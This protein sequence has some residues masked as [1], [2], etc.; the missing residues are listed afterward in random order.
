[1]NCREQILASVQAI[2]QQ[3]GK[4]TFFISDLIDHMRAKGSACN[5]G[6][7]RNQ[8]N[9][10]MGKHSQVNKSTASGLFEHVGHGQYRYTGAT[11]AMAN[12]HLETKTKKA[13]SPI[14]PQPKEITLIQGPETKHGREFLINFGF[15]LAGHWYLDEGKINADLSNLP[16]SDHGLYAFVLGDQVLYIGKTS[17]SLKRRLFSYRRPVPSQHTNI[18]ANAMLTDLLKT[19]PKVEIYAWV[20]PGSENADEL[21]LDKAAGYETALIRKL[22]PPWNK[23]K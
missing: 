13:I 18:R 16:N 12:G 20:D 2:T 10:W 21:F 1:M 23:M 4:D 11:N 17:N 3:T 15:K 19:H 9:Y 8:I 22:Q 6:T 7:I 14:Q 5:A